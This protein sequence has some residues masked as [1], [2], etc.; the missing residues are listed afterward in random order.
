MSLFVA[1]LP[2]M[3]S[4]YQ[5]RGSISG[6]VTDTSGKV[7]PKADVTLTSSNSG[8]QRKTT[9]NSSG[10]Y[11]FSELPAGSYY[12]RCIGRWIQE[13]DLHKCRC[14]GLDQVAAKPRRKAGAWAQPLKPSL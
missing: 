6:T 5:F 10:F 13:P 9:S 7:I 12:R 1:M 2:S 8:E 4:A 14:L 11:Q 3:L